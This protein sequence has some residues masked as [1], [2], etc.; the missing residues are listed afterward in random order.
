MAAQAG[1]PARR[2][3]HPAVAIVLL[4]LALMV[5]GGAYKFTFQ[6]RTPP[7]TAAEQAN[8]DW[9]KQKA[10]ETGGD[11]SKLTPEDAAKVKKTI[12]PMAPLA[13]AG[14]SRGK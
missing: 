1:K 2:Q 12:G 10:K 3:I 8:I 9:I 14:Y 13:F 11:M 6:P 5:L 7:V 4:V